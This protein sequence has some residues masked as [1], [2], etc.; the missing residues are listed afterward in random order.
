MISF[1]L[2]E[3]T[4]GRRF[5][6][7]ADNLVEALSFLP[8]DVNTEDINVSQEGGAFPVKGLWFVVPKPQESSAPVED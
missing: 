6:I 1:T 5:V 2:T 8:G 3:E 7:V 4:G